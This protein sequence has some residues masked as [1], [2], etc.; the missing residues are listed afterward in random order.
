MLERRPR[1]LVLSDLFPDPARPTYGIFVERQT[2]HVQ[3]YC[4]NTVVVPT[5]VFPHLRIW[6]EWRRPGQFRAA[7]EA[8][9]SELRLIPAS[10]DAYGYPVY[11]PRYSAPPRQLIH[12]L[13]GFFAYPA[14]LPLL[15]RLHSQRPFDLIHAHYGTPAGVVGLL[16]RRWM[17]IPVLIWVHGGDVNLTGRQNRVG[18]SITSWA[19]RQADAVVANSSITAQQVRELSGTVEPEIIYLG[20]NQPGVAAQPGRSEGER[21]LTLLSVGH[22]NGHK[23]QQYVIRALRALIDQGYQVRY[24]IVGDGDKRAAMEQLVA[25]LDLQQHVQFVGQVPHD[26]VWPYFADCDI[27]VLPSW[28]EAFGVVYIEAL[29]MG[30]PV[31]GCEGVGGPEDLRRFGDCVELVPR[32]DVPSLTRAIKRLIDDPKRRRAMGDVGRRIVQERFTWER[33]ALDTVALYRRLLK[34]AAHEPASYRTA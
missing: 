8:W 28:P 5:R 11:Y 4:D 6:K 16:A 32:H 12:A 26:K 23:G 34:N 1:T 17:R 27:F 31:I 25:S 30:K 10:S 3:A 29:G 20:G 15:R 2:T 14:V 9:R 33:T 18:R 7:W 22:V 21:P 19:F 24:V 13:W